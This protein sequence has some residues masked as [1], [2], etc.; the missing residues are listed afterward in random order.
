M[1]PTTA[2]SARVPAG[3]FQPRASKTARIWAPMRRTRRDSRSSCSS[4]CRPAVRWVRARAASSRAS[5]A[6][7][8]ARPVSYC[9]T[10]SSTPRP[11]SAPTSITVVIG[12]TP[13]VGVGGGGEQEPLGH[14][15]GSQP[16]HP[17]EPGAEAGQDQQQDHLADGAGVGL[18]VGTVEQRQAEHERHRDAH[19]DLHAAAGAGAAGVDPAAHLQLV[20]RGARQR[21][22][23]VAQAR[24][25]QPGV[26]HQRGDDQV[27]AGVVEVVG[28]LLQR[29]GQRRTH[30]QPVGE[31]GQLVADRRRGGG[32]RGRDRL[33]EADRAGD[34]VAQRLGPRGQ[35]L[36]AGDRHPLGARAPEQ[37]GREEDQQAGGGGQHHPAGEQQ[38]HE[39]GGDG[40]RQAGAEALQARQQRRGLDRLVRVVL[41]G[42]QRHDEQRD[43]G[44]HHGAEQH[45]QQLLGG[46]VPDAPWAATM[47]CGS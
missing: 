42:P 13:A 27:G 21:R 45:D 8:L 44:A 7:P 11:T 36:Q 31:V 28:E 6:A 22:Q 4:A 12:V 19:D 3:R 33:L 32:G 39:P 20:A 1:P 37:R 26:E 41:D 35:A 43:P 40:H 5:S 2:R 16:A 34:R 47:P 38:D 14:L 23:H 30:P 46:H 18:D 17:G 10:S 15:E 9:S 24:A 25:A 29:G